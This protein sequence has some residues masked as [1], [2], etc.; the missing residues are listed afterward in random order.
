MNSRIVDKAEPEPE[1]TPPAALNASLR[2]TVEPGGVSG[3]G[4]EEVKLLSYS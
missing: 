4:R 3:S 1:N 2:V